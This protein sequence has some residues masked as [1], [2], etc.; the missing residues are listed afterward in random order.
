MSGIWSLLSC[1][2]LLFLLATVFF[3]CNFLEIVPCFLIDQWFFP[4]MHGR[5]FSS[6]KFEVLSTG[7][8][9][10][11]VEVISLPIILVVLIS[12]QLDI[13]LVLSMFS[14]SLDATMWVHTGLG[15]RTR[16]KTS[17][18]PSSFKLPGL[19]SY[20][21]FLVVQNTPIYQCRSYLP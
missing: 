9:S 14:P 17:F 1:A 20:I 2:S 10:T 4:P 8:G 11:V 3:I 6:L 18:F 12:A 5:L 21:D 13:L 19:N 7:S 16:L 15:Q